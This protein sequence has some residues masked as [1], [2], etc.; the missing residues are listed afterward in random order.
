MADTLGD[1]VRDVRKVIGPSDKPRVLPDVVYLAYKSISTAAVSSMKKDHILLDNWAAR[2]QKMADAEEQFTKMEVAYLDLNPP[3][4]FWDYKCLK[5]RMFIPYNKCQI[6]GGDISSQGWCMV[7]GSLIP[8]HKGV[9]PIEDILPGD[10]TYSLNGAFHD[11]EVRLTSKRNYT[12]KMYKIKANHLLPLIITPEHVLFVQKFYHSGANRKQTGTALK[13][14]SPEELNS[15]QLYQKIMSGEMYRI[16]Q[17]YPLNEESTLGL[18]EILA[19]YLGLFMAEGHIIHYYDEPCGASFAFG[20]TETELVNFIKEVS[21]SSFGAESK[22][23]PNPRGGSGIN[24]RVHSHKVAKFLLQYFN[25]ARKAPSKSLNNSLLYLPRN[26]QKELLHGFTQGDGHTRDNFSMLGS[27]SPSLVWQSEVFLWRSG[28]TGGMTKVR[29]GGDT[30]VIS[31]REV[32]RGPLYRLNWYPKPNGGRLIEEE[33]G[34]LSFKITGI[35][36]IKYSGLVH[37][38]TMEDGPNFVT[39]G[40]L[41]HNCVCWLPPDEYKRGEWRK[42]LI[43]GKW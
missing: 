10:I 42:E 7:P 31:G 19:R 6:V 36:P 20:E 18:D 43:K 21:K 24:I 12:G 22:V 39:M 16:L 1:Y 29:D 4:V 37:D 38:L 27:S 14:C 13:L 5:C 34:L 23:R 17:P 41:S 28:T 9:L 30:V 35:E 32:N 33:P 2:L 11:N 3:P 8:T 40:G 15:E 25:G 26:L